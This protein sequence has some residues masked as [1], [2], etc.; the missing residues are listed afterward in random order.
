MA[1]PDLLGTQGTFLLYTTRRRRGGK[2][3]G[4]RGGEAG[5][6]FKEGGIRVPLTFNGDRAETRITGPANPLRAGTPPLNCR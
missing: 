4:G 5:K 3:P 6:D 2:R 1:A